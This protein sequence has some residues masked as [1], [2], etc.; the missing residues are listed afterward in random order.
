MAVRGA[1]ARH[2]WRGG[3]ASTWAVRTISALCQSV[4]FMAIS[5]R[6]RDRGGR[7]KAA[8]I[9]CDAISRSLNSTRITMDSALS[10]SL[11]SA[12][13]PHGQHSPHLHLQHG[14]CYTYHA[15]ACASTCLCLSEE[16]GEEGRREGGVR[17]REGLALRIVYLLLLSASYAAQRLHSPSVSSL[18]PGSPL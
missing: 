6:T 8:R 18:M 12:S 15:K 3:C 14:S 7:R 2:R 13:W 4:A 10:D 5:H 16:E 17:R 9:A 11:P 1:P